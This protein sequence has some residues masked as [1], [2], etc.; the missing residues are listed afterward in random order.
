MIFFGE[1]AKILPQRSRRGKSQ[2]LEFDPT[3]DL[4]HFGVDPDICIRLLPTSGFVFDWG[5]TIVIWCVLFTNSVCIPDWCASCAMVLPS[6][7]GALPFSIS[8]DSSSGISLYAYGGEPISP[9]VT[10]M[11]RFF[12]TPVTCPGRIGATSPRMAEIAETREVPEVPRVPGED[13]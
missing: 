12:D 1:V 11:T 5:L 7:C 3:S 10:K 9:Y 4:I 2:F 8:A 13:S 6:L